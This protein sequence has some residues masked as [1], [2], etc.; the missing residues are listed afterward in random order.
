MLMYKTDMHMTKKT[1]W[2][3]EHDSFFSP[4]FLLFYFAWIS[5]EDPDWKKAKGFNWFW[6]LWG[7][8]KRSVS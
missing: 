5:M 4:D 6:F 1:W 2:L 8:E 7:E 3:I